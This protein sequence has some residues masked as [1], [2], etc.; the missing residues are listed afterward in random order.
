MKKVTILAA[1]LT[2]LVALV[3]P[4]AAFAANISPGSFMVDSGFAFNVNE[5]NGISVNY[6]A[7][8]V[9]QAGVQSSNWTPGFDMACFDADGSATLA[10][11]FSLKTVS[12]STTVTD[13]FSFIANAR[14]VT[15]VGVQLRT[16]TQTD[17]GGETLAD[18][19][20]WLRIA[21]IFI[22][23]TYSGTVTYTISTNA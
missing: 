1:A 16:A 8:C 7:N 18:N 5:K 23:S 11:H 2:L 10:N 15:T 9:Y 19:A 3:L 12:A 20:L 22:A 13:V 17:G 6:V 14:Q 4:T 21:P